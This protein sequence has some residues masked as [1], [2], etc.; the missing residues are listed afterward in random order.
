MTQ[1]AVKTEIA[2]L[3]SDITSPVSCDVFIQM[4]REDQ[5]GLKA[6]LLI[7]IKQ[8]RESRESLGFGIGIKQ[9]QHS[10]SIQSWYV[11]DDPQVGGREFDV[12]ISVIQKLLRGYGAPGAAQQISDPETGEQSQILWLGEEITS[13]IQTPEISEET[14]GEFIFSGVVNTVVVEQIQG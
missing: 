2:K 9:I 3:F 14:S 11:N 7:S 6:I 12:L 5:V 10:V 4:P 8:S 13:A 1:L